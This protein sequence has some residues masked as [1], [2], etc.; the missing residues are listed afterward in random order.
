MKTF[1][2]FKVSFSDLAILL[3]SI[4]LGVIISIL[5]ALVYYIGIL[6]IIAIFG[7]V[8]YL[9]IYSISFVSFGFSYWILL[10]LS[11]LYMILFIIFQKIIF[12]CAKSL[13]GSFLIIR[14]IG[15]LFGNYPFEEILFYMKRSQQNREFSFYIYFSLIWILFII[16]FVE[17]VKSHR[18]NNVFRWVKQHYNRYNLYL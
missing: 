11:L 6:V 10:S 18:G 9:L 1:I 17:I 3:I 12:S 13:I 4:L 7:F 5:F 8:F 2:I 16:N 15:L 14:G